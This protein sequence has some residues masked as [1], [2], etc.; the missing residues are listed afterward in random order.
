MVQPLLL[1]DHLQ[2]RRESCLLL[3]TFSLLESH[4]EFSEPVRSRSGWIIVILLKIDSNPLDIQRYFHY[5]YLSSVDYEGIAK[6]LSVSIFFFLITVLL[7]VLYKIYLEES[8][9]FDW[10]II[11]F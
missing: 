9:I 8:L 5:L 2:D 6:N 1:Y 7:L 10:E 11:G 4:C 3:H